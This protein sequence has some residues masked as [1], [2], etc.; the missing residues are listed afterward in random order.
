MEVTIKATENRFF[1]ASKLAFKLAK[2]HDVVR[3]NVSIVEK[4]NEPTRRMPSYGRGRTK[5]AIG[6]SDF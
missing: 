4:I 3:V 6:Q 1:E 5:A 2:R